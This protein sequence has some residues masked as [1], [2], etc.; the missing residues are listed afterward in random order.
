MTGKSGY[1]KNIGIIILNSKNNV[2]WAKRVKEDA[3]QFP[4]GGVKR[5]ESLENAMYRELAEETGLKKPD[6]K[7]LARTK[8]WLYYDV[9]KK[10][11]NQ[12]WKNGYKGQKQIWFL[13]KLIGDYFNKELKNVISQGIKIKIIGDN[14]KLPNK[15]VKILKLTEKKTSHNKKINVNLAINYGS[16]NEIVTSIKN[17]KNIRLIDEKKI[18]SNLSTKDFPDPDILIRTG[19]K[20]R[21]SNFMLW[22]LAYTEIFFLEKLWPD[23]NNQDL[24]R[25]LNKFKSIKRNF[26]NI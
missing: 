3:W 12:D 6:I 8:K 22:Q 5:R 17:I 9:P 7:I 10:L 13:L 14:K 25:V 1:R 23:F 19:G 16:K 2:F 26:G 11:V 15:L 4:Q 18:S 21:L 24:K 20:K